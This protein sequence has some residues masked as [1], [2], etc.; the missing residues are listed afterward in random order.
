[1]LRLGA[2]VAVR[3]DGEIAKLHLA[4]SPDDRLAFAELVGAL[5]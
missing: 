1:M 3:P 2:D 5:S 4:S